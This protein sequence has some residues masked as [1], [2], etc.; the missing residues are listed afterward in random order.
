MVLWS[1]VYSGVRMEAGRLVQRLR[2]EM[3]VTLTRVVALG[4][5]R[6][7]KIDEV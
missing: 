1:V 3:R 5:G 6:L 2:Q 7:K 4:N